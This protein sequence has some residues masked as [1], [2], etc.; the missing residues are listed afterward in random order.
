M[1]TGQKN[2]K[3]MKRII[4]LIALVLLA[5]CGNKSSEN[6]SSPAN[7]PAS[8]QPSN[9][10]APV[11]TNNNPAAETVTNLRP[12]QAVLRWLC[13]GALRD[14]A[15]EHTYNSNTPYEAHVLSFERIPL[16]PRKARRPVESVSGFR[17]RRVGVRGA[18]AEGAARERERHVRGEDWRRRQHIGRRL[19]LR[20][21]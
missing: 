3:T 11:E 14:T 19:N 17:T 20:R 10:G 4:P 13:R 2:Q 6:Q 21:R 5:G 9:S 15:D 8:E 16:G 7:P 12:R 1:S 18:N